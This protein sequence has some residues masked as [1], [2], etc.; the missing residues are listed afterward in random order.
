[1]FSK[2]NTILNKQAVIRIRIYL[3]CAYKQKVISFGLVNIF[4]R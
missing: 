3:K 2:F 1:M 4:E